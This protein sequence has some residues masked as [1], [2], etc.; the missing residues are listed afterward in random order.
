MREVDMSTKWCVISLLLWAAVFGGI[1]LW[2]LAI[3][4]QGIEGGQHVHVAVV[5]KQ[6]E[7]TKLGNP[8][9]YYQVHLCVPEVISDL[10]PNTNLCREFMVSKSLI[11]K[12]DNGDVILFYDDDDRP[13][14]RLGGL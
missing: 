7:V 3:K 13:M 12:V 11:D 8:H 5:Y 1:H 10:M 2:C 6:Y 14:R 9:K 4:I